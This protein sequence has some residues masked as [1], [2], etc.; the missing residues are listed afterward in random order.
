MMFGAS[1]AGAQKLR[2]QGAAS[3]GDTSMPKIRSWTLPLVVIVMM[4]TAS[5][6][7]VPPGSQP[8]LPLSQKVWQKLKAENPEALARLGADLPPVQAPIGPH[9]DTPSKAAE[10]SPQSPFSP[11]NAPIGA[12]SNLANSAGAN[13]SNPLV[14]TDGTVIAHVSCSGTWKKLTPDSSGSY[15]NGTWSTI[16]TM[17]SGH[18]PRFFS[19]AVL[20]DGRVIVEGGEYNT[21]C[22][23]AW[24]NK[25]SIYDPVANTWANVPPPAGWA[26]I[27]DSQATVLANGT[28]F[29]A[30]CC[31]AGNMSALLN[32]T[33]LTW[34]ATGTG[35]FDAFD[36][37]GWTL[38]PDGT[39]LTVDAYVFTGT[40]GTN[41][42]RYN[43]STG[44]WTSAGNTPSV[45]ADCSAA[46]AEGG[47]SPT[48]E[49][50]PQVM[51]YNSSV[52]AFGANTANVVH[53][54]LYNTVSNTWSAGPNLPATCGSGSNLQCTLADAPATILP[55]G[56]VLFAASAGKFHTPTKFY[57]YNP[58]G[59]SFSS[60]PSTADAASIT[61]F[62]VNFVVLPTGQ[63]LEVSTDTSNVQIYTPSGTFAPSLQP[64]VSSVPTTLSPSCS[65]LASGTQFNGLSEGANYGDDQMSNTNYPLV[66]IVNNS[67]GHVFYARTYNHSSRSI[68]PGASTS[69]SFQVASA[70]E[71]G[72]STLFVVANGIP[73]A[74]TA[75]TVTSGSCGGSGSTVSHDLNGDGKSDIAWRDTSGNAAIWLMNGATISQASIIGS[76]ST[77]WQIAGQ[78]DF[79][80][81]GKSDILWRDTSGNVAIWLMNGTALS[82]ASI[83][84]SISNSWQISGTGD[85]NGDG[86]GDIL[87]RDTNGNVAMWF[88]NGVQIS[89][90]TILGSASTSWQIVGT[91]DFNG[92]GK[93]D[94]L[95][96]D[97]SGN[98]AIW[99][100]NGTTVSQAAIIGSISNSWQIVGTGDFN[101]DGKG[102]IVWSD[103]SGN[104]AIWLM[105]STAI[106]QA[107]IIGSVSTTWQIVGTGDFN[108]DGK[109]DLLWRDTSG[110]VATWQMNGVAISQAAILGAI[111][112]AWTIQNNNAD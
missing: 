56:N 36:E 111:S 18:T 87:W 103:T 71:T 22:A 79:D 47:S 60:A 74:G 110:N 46:N 69:T 98:V 20:P 54:A 5:Y 62:Q 90:A 11:E 59:N 99:L 41:T 30:N 9:T 26:Q 61:S 58:T 3:K 4:T 45:L 72:A 88:M 50:G 68:A 97:T 95:W 82:Q 2:I 105:N 52:I 35:K 108:G 93:S 42:E 107:S 64:S 63:I 92:D 19:S 49:M 96:R 91:A 28:Y 77:S 31:D 80:G 39:V 57:E 66:R 38:L 48:Y 37:E 67:S 104:V 70:T 100:M 6:A 34:T 10:G 1:L 73:S 14:L 21:G 43:P 106:S 83:V 25:G 75:I 17:P 101:G 24:T 23:S 102:D 29:Q 53:S 16:A 15:V 89:Q 81:G 44:A 13:L 40:C 8:P 32:A 86:K 94:I 76:V 112:T 33:T 84:G 7:Q 85:F 12:W 27:G 78:R 55:N 65:Y 109:S 51:M